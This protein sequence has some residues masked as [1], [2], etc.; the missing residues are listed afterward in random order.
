M[1]VWFGRGL[2]RRKSCRRDGSGRTCLS[3]S[4]YA[5]WASS[6]EDPLTLFHA[7]HLALP[8]KS[9]NTQQALDDGR[10]GLGMGRAGSALACTVGLGITSARGRPLT[11]AGLGGRAVTDGS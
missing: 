7:S 10:R 4:T 2:S 1:W 8:T 5:F 3:F 9:T 11:H 6:L